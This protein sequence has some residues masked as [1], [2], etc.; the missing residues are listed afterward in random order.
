MKTMGLSDLALVRPLRF[1]DDDAT[2]RAAGAD[3]I[4]DAARVCKTLGEAIAD[5]GKADRWG[6]L[7]CTVR[8]DG[9]DPFRDFDAFRGRIAIVGARAEA[10]KH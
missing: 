4:L 1:P 9:R 2:A 8:V 7:V 6:R 5:C 3:D 10:N